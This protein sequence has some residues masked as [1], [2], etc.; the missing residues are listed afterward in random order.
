[1]LSAALVALALTASPGPLQLVKNVDAEVQKIL[2][3]PDASTEQLSAR[4]DEFIDFVELSK[5][6]MGPDWSKLTRPQQDQLGA[7]M[8]GLLRASYAQKAVKDDRG[9]S[10]NV[11]YGE[12]KIDGNEAEVNTA[13]KVKSDKFTV[14]YKL[15]RRDAKAE[16]RIYDVVTD[17]VSLVETYKDQFKKQMAKN[18][19][20]G[21]IK[22]LKNK[23]E[24]LEKQNAETSA[25]KN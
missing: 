2:K 20:D 11:E 22:T 15:Y 7:T 8:K 19:F 14:N 9:G 16:W 18:G 21:L 4:A 5:R 1:M 17:E 25:K 3:S 13:L 10:A 24:S 23:Q 12:E 6:A